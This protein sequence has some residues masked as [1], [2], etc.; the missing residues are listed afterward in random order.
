LDKVLAGEGAP[1]DDPTFTFGVACDDASATVTSPVVS[2]KAS[3]PAQT[4]ASHVPDGTSCTITETDAHGASSTSFAV[5][6]GTPTTG[7][8]IVVTPADGTTAAVVATNTFE[9]IVL[10][11]VITHDDPSNSA[12]PQT[13]AADPHVVVGGTALP[14]TGFDARLFVVVGTS[15]ILAGLVLLRSSSLSRTPNR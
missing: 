4:I 5:N 13:V 8:H 1:Q 15:L 11:V 12:V 7:N 2:I 14:R 10:G 9:P 6:S 3:D